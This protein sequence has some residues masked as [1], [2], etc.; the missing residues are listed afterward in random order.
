MNKKDNELYNV[1]INM[2]LAMAEVLG[3]KSLMKLEPSIQISIVKKFIN[4][5]NEE[6]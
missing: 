2:L 1:Q 3:D 5:L 6:M 4:F